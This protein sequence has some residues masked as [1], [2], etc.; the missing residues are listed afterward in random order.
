MNL[1]EW[2]KDSE[3]DIISVGD[4]IQLTE[5]GKEETHVADEKKGTVCKLT[6]DPKGIK[7]VHVK[8]DNYKNKRKVDPDLVERIDYP[9]FYCGMR[10]YIENVAPVGVDQV[11][12]EELDKK[13][14]QE[15]ENFDDGL[16]WV[17]KCVDCAD[18]GLE[19]K[20]IR[21]Y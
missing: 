21:R 8:W 4:R 7:V 20:H 19:A 6:K 1:D 3:L 5:K 2:E 10:K 13:I 9:C 11:A 14:R 12:F 15:F 18:S 16:K 17:W